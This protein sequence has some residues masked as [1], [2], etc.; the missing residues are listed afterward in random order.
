MR[1]WYLLSCLLLLSLAT[2]AQQ[3][4]SSQSTS[5]DNSAGS[6]GPI[7]V[8]GCVT[9]INGSFFLATPSG[10]FRLKGDHDSLLGHNGQQVRVTGTVTK[11][12]PQ[13]LKI[14][15]LKKVSDTC[16]Y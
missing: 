11:K 12:E 5:N 9:S 15:H 3:S 14:S 2:F 1:T 13:T 10:Q 4:P 16:Q 8:E 7:T 6:G